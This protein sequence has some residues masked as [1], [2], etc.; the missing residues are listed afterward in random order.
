MV[1]DAACF[2]DPFTWFELAWSCPFYEYLNQTEQ[3]AEQ[4]LLATT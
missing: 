4:P 3:A 2:V 1:C